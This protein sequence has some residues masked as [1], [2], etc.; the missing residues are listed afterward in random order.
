MDCDS[1][2]D[3]VRSVIQN[4]DADQQNPGSSSRDMQDSGCVLSCFKL[5]A[6]LTAHELVVS[7]NSKMHRRRFLESIR[8]HPVSQ[9]SV[10]FRMDS[11]QALRLSLV[12]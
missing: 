2:A 3:K 7:K 5:L 4:D 9:K 8:N 10:R 11:R 1:N 12:T 6:C